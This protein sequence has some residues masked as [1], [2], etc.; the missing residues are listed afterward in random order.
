MPV[1]SL[2][3]FINDWTMVGLACLTLGLAPF[4]PEPHVWGKLRWVA[5]GA[6]GMK[7]M[8]WF[9]LIMHGSPWVLLLRLI[10]LKIFNKN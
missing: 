2:K 5:G 7:P 4:V 6:I 1:S 9:D 3:A 8:D 10:L